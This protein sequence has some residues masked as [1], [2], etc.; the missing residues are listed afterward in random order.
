M[1][2]DVRTL[3]LSDNDD[4][5]VPLTT[6]FVQNNQPEKNVS[7]NKEM[8]MDST[9]I[10][11]IMGQ[12]EMPLEPPMMES[13]PRVQQPVVMQQPMVVQ[14]QQ[15]QQAAAQTKNPFNLTDEQMQAV[16]VAACT[17]AA[18]SKPV[19]EK[20]ANYVPQ[21]LNEQGHRSMVG[22]AATGAVA[23]GIFYVLKKY[24]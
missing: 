5:M 4:G 9:A 14:Q 13:D 22:L 24:A 8:T 11:D 17:A 15:P 6:S 16:V 19:Q 7:Q 1:S 23:A 20:L 10:A 2:T 18:I 12:P 21:F 3:N